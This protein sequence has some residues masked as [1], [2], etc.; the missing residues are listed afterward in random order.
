MSSLLLCC[1]WLIEQ[2]SLFGQMYNNAHY[3][4]MEGWTTNQH[5]PKAAQ[6]CAAFG[7]CLFFQQ[8]KINKVGESVVGCGFHVTGHFDA[9][10]QTFTC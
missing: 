7:S 1:V 2:R 10:V 3:W 5:E 8:N 4:T 9:S 6:P